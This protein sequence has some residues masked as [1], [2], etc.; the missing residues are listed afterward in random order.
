M[1]RLLAILL[2]LACLIP[3]ALAEADAEEPSDALR[4]KEEH[5]LLNGQY[6]LDG[7]HQYAELDI[8]EENP[9]VFAGIG[10]IVSLLEDGSGAIYFGFPECPWCRTLL[11]V[12]VEA[13]AETGYDGTIYYYNAVT[14]RDSRYLD[15]ETGEIVVENEGT[16]NY[17]TLLELLGEYFWE[18]QGL[19]DP[20]L[21]RLYFP[22]MVFVRDGEVQSVH[23]DT[24][25]GQASGYDPLTEEQHAALLEILCAGLDSVKGE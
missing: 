10:D 13:V 24:I 19:N 21:K 12:L 6:T 17:R 15:E 23:I 16:D 20:S 2:A 1:K 3:A 9:F 22:T 4:F 25:E 14:E 8:P 11:P 5:E 7:A 18:Y